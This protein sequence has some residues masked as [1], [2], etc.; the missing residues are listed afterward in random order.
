MEHHKYPVRP[1]LSL[2]KPADV[3]GIISA[4]RRTDS[5]DEILLGGR[6]TIYRLD[7]VEFYGET[8]TD[9]VSA[10]GNMSQSSQPTSPNP[11]IV[12]AFFLSI[13][14]GAVALHCE[15]WDAAAAVTFSKALISDFL[16]NKQY[17]RWSGFIQD[18]MA[19]SASFVS[20][21]S[22]RHPCAQSPPIQRPTFCLYPETS[23]NPNAT[24]RPKRCKRQNPWSD[25]ISFLYLA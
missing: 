19:A 15:D 21:P 8:Y 20:D 14:F 9:K 1:V 2:G 17:L 13:G 3:Q 23:L 22:H 12:S 18:P 6:S 10:Q 16:Q 24:L 5:L 4:W 11:Y 25:K 7:M